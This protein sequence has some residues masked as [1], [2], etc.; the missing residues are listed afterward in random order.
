MAHAASEALPKPQPEP[1]PENAEFQREA[2]H[3]GARHADAIRRHKRELSVQALLAAAVQDPL[4]HDRVAPK[5]LIDCKG[6]GNRAGQLRDPCVVRVDVP[7]P[8]NV[9]LKIEK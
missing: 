2:E 3:D 9:S 6:P 5:P 8:S 7:A 1:Q 4:Q